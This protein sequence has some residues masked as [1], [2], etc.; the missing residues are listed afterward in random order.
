MAKILYGVCGVGSGHSTRAKAVIDHLLKQGHQVKVIAYG[1]AAINLKPFFDLSVIYSPRFYFKKNEIQYLKTL[2]TNLSKSPNLVK[3]VFRVSKIIDNFLPQIIFTDFEPATAI[4]ANLHNLPLVS[5]DNIHRLT[6]A[7]YDVPLKY[8]LDAVTAKA[9]IRLIVPRAD[10]Y[11]I[12]SL[13]DHQP[14]NKKSFFFP[15]ILRQEILKANPSEN[16]YFLV[17][18]SSPNN[19]LVNLLKNIKAQFIVYGYKKNEQTGN[20]QFK[21]N[22]HEGFITDLAGSLGVIATAGFSLISEALC[23]KKPY[24][25][26]PLQGQFEQSLNALEL[27]KIGCGKTLESLE[28]REIEEFIAHLP[29][30]R[31]NLANYCRPNNDRLFDKID[32]LIKITSDSSTKKAS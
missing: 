6:Q 5:I 10:W 3:S 24:L 22:S 26:L 1:Q 15:P 30:F 9:I 2:F 29:D 14:K 11:L 4:A 13:T 32:E 28:S 8:S 25:A 23:L 7:K 21:T 12:T 16:N 18:L 19:R 31:R 20:L 27:E 17:Y